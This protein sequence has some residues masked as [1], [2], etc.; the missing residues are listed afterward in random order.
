R[1]S[2]AAMYASTTS[3][4]IR[5]STNYCVCLYNIRGNTNKYK[6]LCMPLQHPR[7]YAQV[8]TA[9]YASTTSAEIRTSMNCCVCLLQYSLGLEDFSP[10]K[11][12]AYACGSC[13]ALCTSL[14][15][16]S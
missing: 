4:G 2:M 10:R 12:A 15:S 8:Q 13:A 5:T 1:T 16:T 11:S 14:S 6:L 7:E 9:V 3:A